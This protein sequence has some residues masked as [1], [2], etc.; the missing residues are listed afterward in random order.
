M[1]SQWTKGVELYAQELRESLQGKPATKE[2]LLNGA[3]D[4]RQYSEGGCALT[5]NSDIADRLCSPS[6]LKRKKGGDLPPNGQETW[7]AVQ[8]RA[9]FQAARLV[10]RG[11]I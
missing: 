5:C 1:K 3:N 9:L 7:L 10:L 2:A 6:E 11:D 8:A 4:W